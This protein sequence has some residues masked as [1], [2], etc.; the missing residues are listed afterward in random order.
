[1]KTRGTVAAAGAAA[2]TG[3]DGQGSS[4]AAG[5]MGA[6][7]V[8][9]LLI[10]GGVLAVAGVIAFAVQ[11]AGQSMA[12]T[13]GY[14]WSTY[15]G[16]FYTAASAGAGLL[17]VAGLGRWGGFIPA[18]VAARL[19]GLACAL[20]VAASVLILVDL[21]NPAAI[22]LTYTSANVG[23][24][25]FF[26]A[27]ALP[28]C[29]VIAAAGAVVIARGPEERAGASGA[30]ALVGVLA[31]FVLLGVEAWL[32]TTCSGKDAWGVLLGAGPALLQAVALGAAMVALFI[33]KSRPWRLVL[34]GALLLTVVSTV[35]DVVLNQGTG[36]VL[37]LQLAAIASLPTFWLGAA[38]GAAAAVALL[39]VEAPSAIRAAAA[40]GIACVP[41]IKLAVLQGTQSVVAV[42]GIAAPGAFPFEA[43]ELVV[44]LGA[45]GVGVLVYAG[46]L[47][48]LGCPAVQA[49]SVPSAQ[50]APAMD[51]LEPQEVC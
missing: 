30:L 10:V 23:S 29:I 32:L 50:T 16:L 8:R 18:A 15:I 36:T 14:P 26:D 45:V 33:P 43:I 25:V 5:A 24:P 19:F 6:P 3:R 44:A 35:F 38:C 22:L 42:S 2:T 46:A 39:V 27:V 47:T 37:G 7:S 49:A 9:T 34:A 51:D 20:L 17:I 13:G 21:G 12:G 48:V 4:G 28:A 31:G 1:M 11:L 41:L 40:L